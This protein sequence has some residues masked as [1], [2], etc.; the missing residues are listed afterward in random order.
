MDKL[1]PDPTLKGDFSVVAER[2]VYRRVRSRMGDS[3]HDDSNM[4]WLVTFTDIMGLMLTFFVLM[5]SMT[6]PKQEVFENLSTAM[7][8]EFNTYYGRTLNAGPEESIDIKRIDYGQALDL[9]YLQALMGATIDQHDILKKNVSLIPQ[10][11]YLVVSLPQ[12]FLFTAGGAVVKDGSAQAIFA[13]GGSFSRMKNAL[14]VAGH[15]TP[16][17]KSE[18][19]W[20]LSLS[21][22]AAVAGAL[23]KVGYTDP[24]VLRGEADG[25]YNDLNGIVDENT[26]LDLS[27]RVDIDIMNHDGRRKKAQAGSVLP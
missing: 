16:L 4:I 22:A 15:T 27:R 10:G 5:F 20:G 2:K 13:L 8:T 21:R 12:D 9:R 17:D 14:A 26:R 3:G 6:E 23:E 11:D 25:R 1:Y 18:S 24:V 19:K 7:Q